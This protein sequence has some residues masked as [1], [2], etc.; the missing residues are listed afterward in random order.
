MAKDEGIGTLSLIR[1]PN[2]KIKRQLFHIFNILTANKKKFMHEYWYIKLNSIIYASAIIWV[3]GYIGP[4]GPYTIFIYL[5]TYYFRFRS[6]TRVPVV[7]PDRYPGNK[8]P[9]YGS[10]TSNTS[11]PET[12]HNGAFVSNSLDRWRHSHS[13][14]HQTISGWIFSKRCNK[15]QE[16][17]LLILNDN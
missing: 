4:Y 16:L 7:L 6:G 9:G 5:L 2:S 11:R 12:S 3:M 13:M 15:I 8:L 17:F 14:F 10:P 1:R